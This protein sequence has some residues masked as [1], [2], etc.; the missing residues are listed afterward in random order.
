MFTSSAFQKNPEHFPEIRPGDPGRVKKGEHV[1]EIRTNGNLSPGISVFRLIRKRLNA[2]IEVHCEH[3]NYS[4][5][6][7]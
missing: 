4:A 5:K 7:T 2:I 3:H 6:P 1:R